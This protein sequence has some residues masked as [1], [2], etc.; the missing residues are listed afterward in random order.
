MRFRFN[1]DKR[2]IAYL[3]SADWQCLWS[4]DLRRVQLRWRRRWWAS[5]S[6]L[7]LSVDASVEIDRQTCLYVTQ[8][9][10]FAQKEEEE[11]HERRRWWRWEF[12]SI[13]MQEKHK[14]KNKYAGKA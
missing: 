7:I 8:E 5:L 6:R 10:D 12:W 14:Y 13:N 9:A 2:G 4:F 3:F 1:G 11:R